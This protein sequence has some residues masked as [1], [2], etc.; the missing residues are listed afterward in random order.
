MLSSVTPYADDAHL[1]QGC[2]LLW[3][4]NINVC[5]SIGK[6]YIHNVFFIIALLVWLLL[7]N[8][9]LKLNSVKTCTKGVER[10]KKIWIVFQLVLILIEIVI[11]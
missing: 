4:S 6:L 8:H 1:P 11:I 10:L 5:A 3:G 2:G 9:A 7:L